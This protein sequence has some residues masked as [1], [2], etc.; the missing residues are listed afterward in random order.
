MTRVNDNILSKYYGEEIVATVS[1]SVFGTSNRN[2][3]QT[4][5]MKKILQLSTLYLYI[6]QW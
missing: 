2:C 4:S 3:K 6:Y 1:L 5:S